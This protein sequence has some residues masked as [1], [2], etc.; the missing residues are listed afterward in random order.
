[1][2]WMVRVAVVA[3]VMACAV[4][5]GC[6]SSRVIEDTRTPELKISESGTVTFHGEQ[7]AL[8]KVARALKS[9]GV[10]HDQEVNILV[11][12]MPD[13]ALMGRVA[14]E[15]RMAGFTRVVFMTSRNVTSNVVGGK[16]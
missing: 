9:A 13:K 4:W 8:G 7:V 11:P 3:A 16:K 5:S 1:M 2:V 12:G 14:G 15:L 6:V 10:K